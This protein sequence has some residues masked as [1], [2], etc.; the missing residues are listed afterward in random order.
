MK[1]FTEIIAEAEA[2][3][4]AFS[5][6]TTVVAREAALVKIFALAD[7]HA[8]IDV[9]G[10]GGPRLAAKRNHLREVE[11]SIERLTGKLKNGSPA[12]GGRIRELRSEGDMLVRSI[13]AEESR[14]LEALEA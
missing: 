11:L 7:A 1:T 5:S 13:R 9:P 10:L 2:Y 14:L 6:A 12:L 4:K 3:G 8:F